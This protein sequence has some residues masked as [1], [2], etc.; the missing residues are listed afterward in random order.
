MNN[1]MKPYKVKRYFPKENYLSKEN[2]KKLKNWL[3]VGYTGNFI[4]SSHPFSKNKEIQNLL[5]K[6]PYEFKKIINDNIK[7]V[8]KQIII[9]SLAC[10]TLSGKDGKHV[11]NDLFLKYVKTLGDLYYFVSYIKELKNINES[12]Y[13]YII[14]Y[15]RNQSFEKLHKEILIYRDHPTGISFSF[16]LNKCG[17]EARNEKEKLYFQYFL[18]SKS[19]CFMPIIEDYNLLK[20]NKSAKNI[21]KFCYE[22]LPSNNHN[23]L[24]QIAKNTNLNTIL[25]NMEIFNKINS[26][27]FVDKFYKSYYNKYLAYKAYSESDD[28]IK[29]IIIEKFKESKTLKKKVC[30]IVDHDLCG[31]CNDD[32]RVI[33]LP[34][35]FSQQFENTENIIFET[36]DRFRSINIKIDSIFDNIEN[37]TLKLRDTTTIYLD[38]IIGDLIER[39]KKV[40]SFIIWTY[41]KEFSIRKR[42]DIIDIYK[43][44]TGRDVKFVFIN[45]NNNIDFCTTMVDN[46]LNINGFNIYRTDEIIKRFIYGDI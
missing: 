1:Y 43:S 23:N 25:E 36:H 19:K 7:C 6:H 39:E 40:D 38:K 21:E 28:A 46:T 24:E 18:N 45:F 30:N 32:I 8:D 29:H 9:F 20:K 27:N 10:I 34:F 42:P 3:T 13:P 5:K 37:L 26:I 22:M 11:L 33:N 31:I 14:K 4:E 17:L 16:L 2:A 15:I 35:I 12:I 44:Y 41:G